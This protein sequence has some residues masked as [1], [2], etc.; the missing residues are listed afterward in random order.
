LLFAKEVIGNVLIEKVEDG[1]F[2]ENEAKKI[3]TMLLYENAVD[4]FDLGKN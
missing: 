1:Y 2:S 3:A 4:F